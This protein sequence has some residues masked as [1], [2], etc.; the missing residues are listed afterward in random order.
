[1]SEKTSVI[2][3]IC[4]QLGITPV[5]LAVASGCCYTTLNNARKGQMRLPKLL[6]SFLET[7]GYHS[8]DLRSAQETFMDHCRQEAAMDIQSAKDVAASAPKTI[9]FN[10]CSSF[11]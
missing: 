4:D 3:R 10:T 8:S 5:K 11:S 9:T 7:Q 1:M 6:I 2:D